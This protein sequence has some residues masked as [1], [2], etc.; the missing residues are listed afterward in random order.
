M[1]RMRSLCCARAASGHAAAA[2]PTSEM[3]SRRLMG[4]PLPPSVQPYHVAGWN[5]ALC[6]A[7]NLTVDV[8]LWVK[9]EPGQFGRTITALS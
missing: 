6:I 7:T 5:V 2:P 8:M 3:N 9:L 1:R 4:V